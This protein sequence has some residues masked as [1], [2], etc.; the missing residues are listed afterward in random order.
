MNGNL[1]SAKN[2]WADFSIH[3]YSNVLAGGGG[4]EG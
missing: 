4:K 3:V 2:Y 1:I